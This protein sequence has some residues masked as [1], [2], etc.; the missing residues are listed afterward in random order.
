MWVAR[1]PIAPVTAGGLS[2]ILPVNC[3]SVTTQPAS[4]DKDVMPN[5]SQAEEAPVLGIGDTVAWSE[6]PRSEARV[7]VAA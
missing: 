7:G 1:I 2:L 3:A 4:E 6:P 5:S